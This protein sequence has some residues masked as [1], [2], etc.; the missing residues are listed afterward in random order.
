MHLKRQMPC[1]DAAYYATVGEYLIGAIAD[2]AGSAQFSDQGAEQAV[3]YAVAE[4]VL[5]MRT[6]QVRPDLWDEATARAHFCEVISGLQ[7]KQAIL[8]DSLECEVR[9]LA[10][11][12]AM[13]IAS[14]S[15]VIA[16]QVG[17]GFIV[18][19]PVDGEYT[20]LFPPDKGEY[21]NETSFLTQA[22]PTEAMRVG[23]WDCRTAFI[24]ASSDGLER[25]AIKL[26][27]MIPH[28]PFFRPIE[29]FMQSV[30]SPE[31]DDG[32]ITEFLG[33]ERLNARTDD[34]KC[35]LLGLRRHDL[36]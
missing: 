25:L 31:T 5:A 30:P 2:G 32:F 18:T 11:T 35:L 9:E 8:A 17:D 33:S 15:K 3:S 26:A 12:L 27:D 4:T 16:V 10:S 29:D 20:L 6:R 24:C 34:D 21:A 1:Q 28:A 7:H 19:R 13:F 36:P 23:V 22:N 14:P